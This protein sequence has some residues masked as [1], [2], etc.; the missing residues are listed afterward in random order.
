[1]AARGG[2]GDGPP[3][4][5][6]NSRGRG[7]RGGPGRGPK[8][9]RGNVTK[10][11]DQNIEPGI[12]CQ[13]CGLEGHP[14]YRCWNRYDTNYNGGPP[15]KTAAATTSSSYGV[16]TNW[17]MDT[18]ATDHI[19]RDLEKLTIRD[20][21]NGNEQVHAANGAGMNICHI[22]HSS[23]QSPHSQIHLKNILHVPQ[24]SKNLVS[25]HRSARD[26]NA[27]LEFH[28]NHFFIKEQGT[29]R[30]LLRGR[31]EGGLYPLE[32]SSNKQALGAFKPSSSLWHARL[33]HASSAV[34]QQILDNYDLPYVSNPNNNSIC[35][36]CQR[37]KSHQLPYPKSTSI[38]AK[39]CELIFSDVWG[40]APTSVGKHNYYVSFIDDYSKFT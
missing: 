2:R 14:A 38:S 11:R 26:N 4:N 16:D 37:G 15:Q 35:D 6:T 36:A 32:L 9:G 31:S 28:P 12:I 33:G 5:F 39:P 3:T 18:R 34:V 30:T 8:G 21:Y 23:L 7:G 40:P 10:G 17:Y 19:T 22:G 13:V 24:T 27:F 1:M 20:R 29:K 25:V